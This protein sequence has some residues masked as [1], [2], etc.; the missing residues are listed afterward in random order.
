[1]GRSSDSVS[2]LDSILP[3]ALRIWFITPADL[4]LAGAEIE[5]ARLD[6]HLGRLKQVLAP[7]QNDAPFD[8]ILLDCPPSLGILM[9]NALVAADE[10]LVPIQCEYYALEGFQRRACRYPPSGGARKA[11]DWRFVMTMY[12]SRT[13][14]SQQV[15]EEVA[16]SISGTWVYRTMIHARSVLVKRQVLAS[17]SSNTIPRAQERSL[18]RNGEEFLGRQ[19]VV[20]KKPDA[21]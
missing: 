10:L 14:L 17:R 4:D 7:L 9:T 3:R 13:N 15:T 18:S 16:K 5:V 8:F 1:M 19:K 20:E 21:A 11:G 6:D 2:I 12:D